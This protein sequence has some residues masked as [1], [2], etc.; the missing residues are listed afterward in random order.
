M[1]RIKCFCANRLIIDNAL[2]AFEIFHYMRKN[3]IG[4]VGVASLKLD[5]AKAYDRIKRGFIEKVIRSMGFPEHWVCL[6]M[7]CVSTI[8]FSVHLNV[9]QCEVFS[10]TSR[11]FYRFNRFV[12]F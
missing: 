9:I 8:S 2:I 11:R 5:M 6:I 7:K 4:N 12:Q 1:A 10:V 3:K